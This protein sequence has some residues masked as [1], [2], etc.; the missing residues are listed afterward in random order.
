MRDQAPSLKAEMVNTSSFQ[1]IFLNSPTSIFTGYAT[2]LDRLVDHSWR[3]L[4]TL[5]TLLVGLLVAEAVVFQA[6]SE[7]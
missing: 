5:M 7:G 1:Y 2:V 6:S 4:G 3:E